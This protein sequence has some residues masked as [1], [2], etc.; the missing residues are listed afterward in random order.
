MNAV[1]TL[2]SIVRSQ[3]FSRGQKLI[4]NTVGKVHPNLAFIKNLV[5]YATFY[6]II[7][8]ICLKVCL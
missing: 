8:H 1:Y 4:Q 6:S 3:G 7:L 2:I 5:L